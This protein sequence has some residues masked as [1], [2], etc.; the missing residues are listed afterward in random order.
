MTKPPIYNLQWLQT[1]RAG[2]IVPPLRPRVP[3][4]AGESVIGSVEPDFLH[5]IALQPLSD[6]HHPLLK[7]ERPERL[8]WRLMGD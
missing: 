7:E 3:L 1:L 4:W 6:V 2:A 5:Q 8:G